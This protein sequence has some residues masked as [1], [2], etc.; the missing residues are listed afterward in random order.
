[1]SYPG[2]NGISLANNELNDAPEVRRLLDDA[3]YE[4]FLLRREHTPKTKSRGISAKWYPHPILAVFYGLTVPRTKE[5]LLLKVETFRRWLVENG[6][7]AGTPKSAS[8]ADRT[9]RNPRRKAKNRGGVDEVVEEA[10][11]NTKANSKERQLRLFG[12]ED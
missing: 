3:T 9:L 1:M 2:A 12:E 10:Q 11:R 4:C 5:P 7:L 6:V 8:S